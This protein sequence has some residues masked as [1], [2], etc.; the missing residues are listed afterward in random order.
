MGTRIPES[1]G[2]ALLD[3]GIDRH[4]LL[5]LDLGSV[6]EER[7]RAALLANDQRLTRSSCTSGLDVNQDLGGQ[8]TWAHFCA[9]LDAHRCLSTLADQGADLGIRASGDGTPLEIAAKNRSTQALAVLLKARETRGADPA[10]LAAVRNDDSEIARR[11]LKA[12]TDEGEGAA[13]VLAAKLGQ[14]WMIETISGARDIS[15]IRGAEAVVCAAAGGHE[16]A[17][18]VLLDGSP[19]ELK[20][21]EAVAA[22]RAGGHEKLAQEL[23]RSMGK[24]GG[25]KAGLLSRLEPVGTTPRPKLPPPEATHESTVG[26]RRKLVKKTSTH[27]G[28]P[29]R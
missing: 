5:D 19:M 1:M 20:T 25:L 16:Q 14:V 24:K 15:F 21:A 28:A 17:L 26:A 12:T 22:A 13:L 4:D 23:E 8:R 3:I 7:M 6:A 18:R 9:V 29:R 27:Q 2:R 10:L 11:L